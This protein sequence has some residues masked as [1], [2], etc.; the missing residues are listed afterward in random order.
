MAF[1]KDISPVIAKMKAE[2]LLFYKVFDTDGKTL[3]DCNEDPGVGMDTAISSLEAIVGSLEGTIHILISGKSS[4]EK[5]EG[6]PG[7]NYK[8]TL[9]CGSPNS[10]AIGHT[11]FNQMETIMGLMQQNF[12]TQLQMFTQKFE[13]Q[14]KYEDLK[15]AISDQDPNDHYIQFA[16]KKL[17]R[18]FPDPP[19]NNQRP[20][21]SINGTGSESDKKPFKKVEMTEDEKN[22]LNLAVH[23]LL[24]EDPKFIEHLTMLAELAKKDKDIYEM[25]IAKLKKFS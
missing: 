2:R 24:E 7:K 1:I 21:A 25:A 8:F 19:Q 11:G 4:K 15:R 5:G 17:D 16:M 20:V 6:S 18:M 10:G 3:I 22:K 12:N 14:K 9:K 23:V 13:D